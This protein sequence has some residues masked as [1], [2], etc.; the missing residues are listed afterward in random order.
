M[1]LKIK[2]LSKTERG[3]LLI[4][5]QTLGNF[6]DCWLSYYET[7]LATDK[8][9]HSTYLIYKILLIPI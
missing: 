6:A 8:I 4:L 5:K 1:L 7:Q 3:N 9:K 2:V